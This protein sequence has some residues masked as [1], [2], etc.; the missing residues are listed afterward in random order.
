MII[1]ID[2]ER[3]FKKKFQQDGTVVLRNSTEALQWLKNANQNATIDQIWF[4]HDLGI[5]NGEI[6]TIIPV[7]RYL[8][9]NLS[10][11][12]CL[13]IKEAIVH[14]SNPVGGKE[15]YDSM[16][17]FVPTHRVFAGDYLEVI[18]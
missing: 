1:L 13:K 11:K 4:D 10:F 14:T 2:D 9:N 7:L 3:S 6:D 12:N 8:E 5:V 16:S 15:L 17:R 18:E